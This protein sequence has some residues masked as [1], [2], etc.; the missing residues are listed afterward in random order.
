MELIPENTAE[1]LHQNVKEPEIR[2]KDFLRATLKRIRPAILSERR[3]GFMEGERWIQFINWMID[4]RILK[5]VE[6]V[7]LD[8]E[9][10]NTST[11][12]T[13]QFFK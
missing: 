12:Y 1:V 7:F 10:V 11:L 5:D 8:Y 4:H 3:W 13:N 2:N 6:V 9:Q